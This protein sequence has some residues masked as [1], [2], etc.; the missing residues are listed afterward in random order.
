MWDRFQAATRLGL[1]ALSI[2]MTEAYGVVPS[3]DQSISSG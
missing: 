1:D 3:V 2:S